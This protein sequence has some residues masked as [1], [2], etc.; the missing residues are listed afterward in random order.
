MQQG[1]GWRPFP[2]VVTVLTAIALVESMGTATATATAS[3][4]RPA[5]TAAP[6]CGDGRL[7]VGGLPEVDA[8]FAAE[9]AGAQAIADAWDE[10]SYLVALD[11]TC[12][13]LDPGFTV[14]ATYFSKARERSL[15]RTADGEVIALD[16]NVQDPRPLDVEGLSFDRLARA[17][18]SEGIEPDAMLTPSG[19]AVRLNVDND[20][21]RFGPDDLPPDHVVFHLTVEQNNEMRDLF[22]DAEDG[23]VYRYVRGTAPTSTPAP[24]RTP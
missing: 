7:T 24:T 2:L 6:T 13:F 1:D 3:G 20:D 17:L 11:V 16:P 22:V 9:L 4:Q 21:W 19:V 18:R 8:T 12:R 23:T 15:F 5:A 14:R 10:E